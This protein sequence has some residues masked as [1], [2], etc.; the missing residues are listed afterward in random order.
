M[1]H[2]PA[3]R[4]DPT[5]W[6]AIEAAEEIAAGERPVSQRLGPPRWW[7]SVDTEHV[8]VRYSGAGTGTSRPASTSDALSASW[9]VEPATVR[10]LLV[11]HDVCGSEQRTRA[12]SRELCCSYN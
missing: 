12:R 8:D 4:V 5:C 9:L 1:W 11:R 3:V 2:S 6:E 10:L 7:A